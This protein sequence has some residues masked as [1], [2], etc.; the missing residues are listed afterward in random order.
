LL[1]VGRNGH[2]RLR[3]AALVPLAFVI[4]GQLS[5][6]PAAHAETAPVLSQVQQL[7][8]AR[9]YAPTLVFHPQEHYFPTAS[10][11][12]PDGD[13]ALAAW[14]SRVDQYRAL[15]TADKLRR[16]A[17]A[18]RV[19]TRIDDG[20][21]EV[22]VEYWCYYVYNAY[23][24]RGG[25]FPYRVQDDHP[26]DLERL[27]L[28]LRPIGEWSDGTGER[29]ARDAFRLYRVVANAHDGSIAPNQ[30]RARSRESVALPLNVMVERGSHAMAADI[31]G[32]GRFTPGVDS[33]STLKAQWGIRDTGS[34]WRWY[35]QSFMDRRDASAIRLCGPESEAANEAC[36]RYALYPVESLQRSFE[37]LQLSSADRDA[38]VGRTS[39]LVRTFGDVRVE[40]L[41]VPTDPGNGRVLDRMLRRRSSSETGFV[42]GF[43]TV[44]HAPTLVIGR[45]KYWEVPSGSAPDI[46]VEGVALLASDRRTLFEGTLW[47]SYRV[48]A[49]TNVLVGFGWFSESGSASVAIGTEVRIGRFR[50]RP[51]WRLADGGFDSRFTTT[52]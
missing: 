28:V 13:G 5:Q 15:T 16:A 8:L 10:M 7:A 14:S 22:V 17:L 2:R 39:W 36:P 19:F 29:W 33:S 12:P 47:G 52:F 44:D 32:D 50:V 35:L 3:L 1:T 11:P 18:Y 38:I 26:H 6:P 9:V 48:D 34:T 20:H 25:W 42:A 40:E 4:A 46:L 41:M 21:R 27:Y 51:S 49:I 37:E 45:R 43:T 23:T 24:V 30:Y 31:D